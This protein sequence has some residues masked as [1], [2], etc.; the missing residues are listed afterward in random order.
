MIDLNNTQ[1]FTSLSWSGNKIDIKTTIQNYI[2]EVGKKTPS[3]L[4]NDPQFL[5]DYLSIFVSPYYKSKLTPHP[6]DLTMF[7]TE[8]LQLSQ[9]KP[10]LKNLKGVTMYEYLQSFT[11]RFRLKKIKWYRGALYCKG[12]VIPLSDTSLQESPASSNKPIFSKEPRFIK[13]YP[14]SVK[15]ESLKSKVREP[16]NR[17]VSGYESTV[18]DLLE[19]GY[20]PKDCR[21]YLAVN[22][23]SFGLD[24][25]IHD[26]YSITFADH[27]DYHQEQEIYN[28]KFEEST[29]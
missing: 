2:N 28:Q 11:G 21:T 15:T 12:Q 19:A 20:T 5:E 26:D 29:R 10:F 9:Y 1:L 24:L 16:N 17:I 7:V 18:R 8:Y 23:P 4:F 27:I 14:S 6:R 13:V 25:D 22:A 3:R